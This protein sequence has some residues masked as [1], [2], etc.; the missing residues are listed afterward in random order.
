MFIFLVRQFAWCANI[1]EISTVESRINI[2]STQ[3]CS[4]VASYIVFNLFF[5]DVPYIL[6]FVLRSKS[7]DT[8]AALDARIPLQEG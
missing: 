1:S 8:G 6:L 3:F 4:I 5:P 2:M 7:Y